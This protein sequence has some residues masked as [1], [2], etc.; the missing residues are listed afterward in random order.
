MKKLSLQNLIITDSNVLSIEE[1]RETI[2]GG[3]CKIVC[4]DC[5]YGLRIGTQV[6]FDPCFEQPDP[7][8][9]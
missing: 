2:G 1:K 4:I 8:N 3:G 7:C 6:C 9:G 5:E